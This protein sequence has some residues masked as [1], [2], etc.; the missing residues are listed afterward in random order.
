MELK[1]VDIVSDTFSNSGG[2]ELFT[3]LENHVKINNPIVLSFKDS[4]ALSSSFLN[5]SIGEL[6]SKY[7]FEAFKR[8]VKPIELTKSQ[9]EIL[10]SYL[11]SCGERV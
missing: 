7:G 10:L 4:H 3:V 2:F 1:L 9:A 8:N 11:R 5:S 6:I